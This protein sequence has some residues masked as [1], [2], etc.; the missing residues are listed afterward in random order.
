[1][2]LCLSRP[3]KRYQ[4]TKILRYTCCYYSIIYLNTTEHAITTYRC[5]NLRY[6]EQVN[7]KNT[8]FAGLEPAHRKRLANVMVFSP[9]VIFLDKL[10]LSQ[11]QSISLRNFGHVLFL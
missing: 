4:Q 5:E 11:L 9:H 3:R 7:H 6:T 8:I 2:G 1:M 10:T